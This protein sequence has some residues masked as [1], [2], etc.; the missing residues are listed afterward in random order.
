MATA[1]ATATG[2]PAPALNDWRLHEGKA[3][4]VLPG[5]YAGRA[6]LVI[7]S[8]PYDDLRQFA[9]VGMAAWDFPAVAAADCAGAETGRRRAGLERG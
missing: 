7:T 2:T 5:P 4:D 6:D 9:G 8:P 3:Q 1:K